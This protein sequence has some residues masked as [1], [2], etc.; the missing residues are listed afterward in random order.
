MPTRVEIE[1]MEKAKD[2]IKRLLGE[3]M[4]AANVVEVIIRPGSDYSSGEAIL[5]VQ[6]VLKAAPKG[7][8]IP[9][10]FKIRSA[11]R[12][13]LITEY[14]DERFPYFDFVGEADLAE[15]S[16]AND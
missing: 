7:Q 2:K 13:W 9:N 12:S 1:E 3:K 16:H 5:F 4:P 14:G 6:V 15:R 11:F 8:D 10:Q